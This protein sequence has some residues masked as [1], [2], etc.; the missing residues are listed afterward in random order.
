MKTKSL[1]N[2]LRIDLQ[3]FEELQELQVNWPTGNAELWLANSL[4]KYETS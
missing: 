2:F 4:E 1:K 3:T